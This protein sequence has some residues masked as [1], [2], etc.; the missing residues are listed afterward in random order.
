[1]LICRVDGLCESACAGELGNPGGVATYG[2]FIC[3]EDGRPIS[4]GS[5]V[6]GEGEG[7]DHMVAEYEAVLHAL[8]HL[9]REKRTMEPVEVQNDNQQLVLE[10]KGE[11]EVGAGPYQIRYHQARELASQFVSVC[12]RRIDGELNWE[13]DCLA[14]K[15]YRRYLSEKRSII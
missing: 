1:M 4:K 9:V 5:G 6:I 12:F 3:D 13:A 2:F 8:R 10:M 15:E 14:R 7:M 11:K